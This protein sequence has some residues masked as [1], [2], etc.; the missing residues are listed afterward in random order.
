Q[1]LASPSA[2]I[3]LPPPLR[4]TAGR[5]IAR[6]DLRQWGHSGPPGAFTELAEQAIWLGKAT[7]FAVAEKGANRWDVSTAIPLDEAI[8]VGDSLLIAIAART[9]NAST[10]DGSAVVGIRVQDSEPPHAGFADNLF[11]VGPGWQLVRVRTTATEAIPAGRATVA[12]HFSEAPQTV[13][14][15][16]VYVFKT[17]D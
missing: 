8:E 16:P 1:A 3:E 10:E 15:G 14:I 5:L 4:E 9:E 6:P 2:T 17:Q 11:K 13:D 12:L 7:R